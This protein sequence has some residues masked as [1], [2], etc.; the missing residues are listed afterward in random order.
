[1]KRM[2]IRNNIAALVGSL[3]V[4]SV[5]GLSGQAYA[6]SQGSQTPLILG[7]GP[8][9]SFQDNFNPFSPSV[10]PDTVGLIYQPLFYFNVVGPNVY[11][12]LGVKDSWSNGNR[13]LTVDLRHG[14]NWSDGTSFSS[15]DVVFTFN[16][17]KKY[18]ALDTNGVWSQLTSVQSAGKYSVKFNFKT[19]D[20]PFSYY[21]LTAPVVPLHIWSKISNPVLG[22]NVKPIGT[23]PYLLKT[24]SPQQI[25]MQAN[26]AYWGGSPKV[27]LVEFPAFDS[28]TSADLEMVK[29][30]IDWGGWFIPN[31]QQDFVNRSPATNHYWFP[32]YATTTLYTNLK[33]PLLSQLPV[34]KAISLAINRQKLDT[35]GEYGFNPPA[36]SAGLVLPTYQKW[37][38][39][40][41]P[42]SDF[43]PQY[44]PQ[45][46]MKILE[47]AGFKKNS[48]GIFT[49]RSGKPLVFNLDVVSGW[50]DWDADCTLMAQ[51]LKAIG[52]QV[53]VHEMQYGAY[54]SALKGGTYQLAISWQ[55]TGGYSPYYAYESMLNPAG[56]WNIEGW[57]NPATTNALNQYAQTTNFGIQKRAIDTIEK[58]MSEQLPVIPLVYSTSFQEYSTTNFTGFPTAQ[59]PYAFGQPGS[60]LAAAEIILHLK[61]R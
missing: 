32:L 26:N 39:K 10:N 12:L 6:S 25:M 9:G 55:N 7:T 2:K 37:A 42:S 35:L 41:L 11:P 24:F 53:N 23:G 22:T 60:G 33:D 56:S 54:Y 44:N 8:N 52:I 50:T 38:D 21:V 61:H 3:L 59:N 43:T 36:S 34:R 13:T 27:K 57:S 31:I 40:Q 29:G 4:V 14:V 16:M 17:L 48:S 30:Q 28:N 51:Q 58:V 49:S 5:I 20:V 46:A 19:A 47:K 45:G 15:A 18:P 1:M